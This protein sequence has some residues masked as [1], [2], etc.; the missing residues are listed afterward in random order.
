[1]V[2][3]LF[4][5]SAATRS[6]HQSAFSVSLP[7][8]K[9]ACILIHVSGKSGAYS[10]ELRSTDGV[11]IWQVPTVHSLEGSCVITLSNGLPAKGEYLLQMTPLTG[12]GVEIFRLIGS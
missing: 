12:S 6:Q 3:D 7:V 8:G 11:L 9:P 5:E 10:A 2:V 4:P 1:L